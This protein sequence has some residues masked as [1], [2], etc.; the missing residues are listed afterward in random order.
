MRH[1]HWNGHP[2]IDFFADKEFIDF[3]NSLNAEMKRLQAKGLGSNKRQAEPITEQE[4][5]KLWEMGLLG[6]HCPQVLL[7]TMIFYNG[8]YFVL[9]S[10]R[11]HRQLRLR[12]RQIKFFEKGERSYL[13]YT[14]DVSK[15]QTRRIKRKEYHLQNCRSS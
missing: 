6:D 15:K 3:K 12:P 5:D 14:E 7:D 4:E 8:L 13:R 2:T 11:E 10:G 1:L 9:R